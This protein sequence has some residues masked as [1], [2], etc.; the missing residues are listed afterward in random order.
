MLLPLGAVR[1]FQLLGVINR[2]V[3]AELRREPAGKYEGLLLLE[4][5]KNS[6]VHTIKT[7]KLHGQLFLHV[8]KSSWAQSTQTLLT[9]LKASQG[10]V[11]GNFLSHI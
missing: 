9:S 2:A 8:L 4:K 3:K 6:P 1:G 5:T 10:F 11:K 7:K